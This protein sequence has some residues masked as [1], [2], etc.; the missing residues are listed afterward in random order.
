[1][2]LLL[3]SFS[4]AL[5]G[6][7]AGLNAEI[8]S[9]L[10]KAQD[11]RP[12]DCQANVRSKVDA[13]AFSYGDVQLRD[14]LVERTLKIVIFPSRQEGTVSIYLHKLGDCPWEVLSAAARYM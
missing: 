4:V 14:S 2:S 8:A 3:T 11:E 13:L 9:L 5:G 7:G 10:R 6:T 12:A 1:M